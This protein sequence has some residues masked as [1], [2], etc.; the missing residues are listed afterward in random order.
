L[1]KRVVVRGTAAAIKDSSVEN[2]A[3]LVML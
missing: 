1:K 3:L 2:M